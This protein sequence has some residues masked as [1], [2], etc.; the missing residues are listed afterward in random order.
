MGGNRGETFPP[1]L[2][3]PVTKLKRIAFAP[4]AAATRAFSSLRFS[5]RSRMRAFRLYDT[6]LV[7]WP[8]I[9]HIPKELALLLGAQYSCS[10]YSPVN[11]SKYVSSGQ[12]DSVPEC[13]KRTV[14]SFK[15]QGWKFS[16]SCKN[17]RT[18]RNGRDHESTDDNPVQ[19]SVLPKYNS[20]VPQAKIGNF[21]KSYYSTSLNPRM[22]SLYH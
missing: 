6:P 11:Y 2:K 8:T 12:Q 7:T 18:Q 14:L 19:G 5:I 3:L 13:R 16:F 22:F 15:L 20:T 21:P 17:T 1:S 10:E 9:S 4:L